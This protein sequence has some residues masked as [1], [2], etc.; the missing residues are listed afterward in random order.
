M[1]RY[2]EETNLT[3]EIIADATASMGFGGK[4]AAASLLAGA[5]AYVLAL[6]GDSVGVSILGASAAETIS[7]RGRARLRQVLRSLDEARPGGAGSVLPAIER[8]LGRMGRRRGGLVVVVSDLFSE[9]TEALALALRSVRGRGHD[10]LLLRVVSR[11]ELDLAEIG[12]TRYVDPETGEA[13]ETV[14]EEVRAEYRRR[15]DANLAGVSRSAE[16][17]GVDHL[18]VV[19]EEGP[20]AALGRY[21]A[22]RRRRVRAA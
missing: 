13:V 19:A 20:G 9:E 21:L 6:Q 2:E 1:K 10:A 18:L 17:L 3:C 16:A 5:V 4:W 11:G 14:P 8:A 12:P 7:R 15:L 22:R